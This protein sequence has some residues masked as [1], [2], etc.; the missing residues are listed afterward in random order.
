MLGGVFYLFYKNKKKQMSPHHN[1]STSSH[2]ITNL[3]RCSIEFQNMTA[4]NVSEKRVRMIN[5][6]R[7][8]ARVAASILTTIGAVEAVNN[9]S[10]VS[11]LLTVAI[12][13]TMDRQQ[14]DPSSLVSW[15]AFVAAVTPMAKIWFSRNFDKNMSAAQG[16]QTALKTSC[17]L[18]VLHLLMLGR[19][20]RQLGDL[21]KR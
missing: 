5:E 11:G 21:E 16:F 12:G 8:V 1:P 7:G 17:A 6:R 9:D 2:N 10:T 19:R 18:M 14:K 15:F 20:I 3:F 4:E 13:L